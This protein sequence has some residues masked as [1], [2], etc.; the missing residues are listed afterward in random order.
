MMLLL[1]FVMKLKIFFTALVLLVISAIAIALFLFVVKDYRFTRTFPY[2]ENTTELKVES[3]IV[4]VDNQSSQAEYTLQNRSKMDHIMRYFRPVFEAGYTNA[5]IV[6]SDNIQLYSTSWENEIPFSY[7]VTVR[8]I[9][10]LVITMHVDHE[11]LKKYD[12]TTQH[13]AEELDLMVIRAL[14]RAEVEYDP[15]RRN[16]ASPSQHYAKSEY[17]DTRSLEVYEEIHQ[18]FGDV[19]FQF[20]KK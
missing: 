20:T 3:W 15:S 11:L 1:L 19:L 13:I 4:S 6:F 9:P 14:T 12:W 17:I 8:E 7:S 18:Q 2:Y 5:T 16:S 10:N